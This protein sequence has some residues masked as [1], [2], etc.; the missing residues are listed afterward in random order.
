MTEVHIEGMDELKAKLKAL[1][2][3][4]RKRALRNALAAGARLV[5]QA[6]RR[7]TPTLKLS[8]Y[9]GASAHRR[10]VRN[11]GTVRK[12]ISVRTS[13]KSRAQGDV[14]VFVNV[15]P[16][17]QGKRGARSPHDPYYWRW[18]NFGWVPGSGKDSRRKR[19][20]GTATVGARKEGA[21]FLRS[22]AQ[23]LPRALA[24]IKAA[25]AKQLAKLNTKAGL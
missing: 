7:D 4:L 21:H 9:S 19:R 11:I 10:G 2:D 23:Q 17:K 5:Q 22:G 12:A 3:K 8:T 20:K 16:A 13:K 18:L 1:P 25:L 6:M 14:G 24:T 15:R